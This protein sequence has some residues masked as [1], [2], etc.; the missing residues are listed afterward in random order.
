MDTRERWDLVADHFEALGLGKIRP[1][2]ETVG[3][4]CEMYSLVRVGGYCSR[5]VGDLALEEAFRTW[6]EFSGDVEFPIT[7]P[8]SRSAKRAYCSTKYLWGDDGYGEARR[9]LC[10]HVASEFRKKE[11]TVTLGSNL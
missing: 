2:D 4:C 6:P 11:L 7:P 8:D 9:R 3:I 10:L 5:E 1:M